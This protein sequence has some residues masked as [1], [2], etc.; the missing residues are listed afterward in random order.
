MIAASEVAEEGRFLD[1]A[2]RYINSKSTL[3]LL[4]I[5]K[6]KQAENTIGLFTRDGLSGNVDS[7]L[8]DL[9]CQWYQ[10]E[11]AQSFI[12]SKKYDKVNLFLK[13][14]KGLVV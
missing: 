10:L 4:R 9:Q 11:C 5:D 1:L 3:Y 2:D 12:R 14:N 8:H 7:N 6:T 13:I